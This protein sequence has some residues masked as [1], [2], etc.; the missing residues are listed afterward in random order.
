MIV[1]RPARP[2]QP[3]AMTRRRPALIALGALALLAAAERP[4]A[5]IRLELHDIADVSPRRVAAALDLG[6]V[7]ARVLVTWSD[8]RIR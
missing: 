3:R 8:T 7:A 6:V 2:A 1:A 5:D 4:V